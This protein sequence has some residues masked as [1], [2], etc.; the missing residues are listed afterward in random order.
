METTGKKLLRVPE[1]TFLFWVVKSLSTTVG[2]TTSDFFVNL[3]LGMPLMAVIVA[4]LMGGLFSLQFKKYQQYVPVIYWSLVVLMSVEGTLITDMLADNHLAS[5][6]TL[7]IVFTLAMLIGFTLWYQREKTLS[8]HSIDTAS[9]E[10]YYWIVILMAFALG[11]AAG[12]LISEALSQGYGV[13]LSLFSSLIVLVAV[14]YYALK[15]NAVLAFWLAYILTRPFGAS[16]GD[17]LSQSQQDG[18]LG[19]GLGAINGLFFMIIILCVIWMHQQI[20]Q[21]TENVARRKKI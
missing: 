11:T 5:L 7:T 13:A 10:A 8:I 15:L 17:Y 2:E 19:F 12:D 6:Q 9:R 3:G 18:G 14:A 16:L 4:V 20:S 21:K 1:V